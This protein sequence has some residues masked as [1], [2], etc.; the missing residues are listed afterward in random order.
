[1]KF[2][3]PDEAPVSPTPRQ[4]HGAWRPVYEALTTGKAVELEWGKDFNDEAKD[5]NAISLSLRRW[6]VPVTIRKDPETGNLY[7]FKKGEAP[8]NPDV[9]LTSVVN[10][11]EEAE[12]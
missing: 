10:E 2:I 3:N 9:P 12:Q 4:E 1:M 7:V 8:V 6:G 5:R 11:Y